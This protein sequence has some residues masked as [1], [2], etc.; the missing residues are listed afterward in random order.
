[1]RRMAQAF[2]NAT[3][4]SSDITRQPAFGLSDTYARSLRLMRTLCPHSCRCVRQ[5]L[6]Y[7]RKYAPC[8]N[9]RTASATCAAAD[10]AATPYPR[11]LVTT[12]LNDGRVGYWEAIKWARLVRVA[13][14]CAD[15][16]SRA[17]ANNSTSN[18]GEGGGRVDGSAR[19]GR[20]STGGSSR[21]KYC[22]HNV[23]L[24]V[25]SEGGHRGAVDMEGHID[26]LAQELAFLI[27][28]VGETVGGKT[29]DLTV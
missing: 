22:T 29:W 20:L 28:S 2:P 16:R 7:M 1:V 24:R 17:T 19:S 12:A 23:L 8:D 9:V 18:G 27:D 4:S 13:N 14:A 11:M 26:N 3:T 10:A 6:Q 21:N 15:A 25:A 5:V